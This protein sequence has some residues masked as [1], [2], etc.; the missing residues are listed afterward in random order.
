MKKKIQ[1]IQLIRAGIQLI[2]F[3]LAPA[4]F[5]RIFSAIGDI[6]KAVIG[7]SFV[8]GEQIGN[9][10]LVAA[11]FI[12]TFI[13][14]RF[15]CGFVCSFGAMQDLLW[16]A[17]R[18]F[19]L[20]RLPEKADAVLKYAKYAV[21]AFV[22]L[23]V[24]TFALPG[25]T[26]WSPWAVFGMYASPWKGVPDEL[27]FLSVGGIMLAIIIVG[28]LF[29]ERFFCKYLCP[30]GA[31][32]T[33]ASHFRIF[34]LKRNAAG[35][36][37]KCTVCTRKC[38]MAIP[39]YRYDSVRSGECINCMKCTAC[40]RG[41]MKAQPIP[42]VSGTVAAAALIGVSFAGTIS[43]SP[44][45]EPASLVK[46][47]SVGKFKD[48]IYTGSAAGYR[49]QTSVKVMVSGGNIS[50]VTIDQSGDDEQFLAQAQQG[51]IPAILA[52]QDPNVATVSG[53]TYS[54]Q[55]IINAVADALD[56]QLA[57][58]QPPTQTEPPTTQVVAE[59][60]DADGS[61]EEETEPTLP[62]NSGS[63]SDGTYT[64]FGTGFRGT[65]EVSVTVENG[66]ITQIEVTS[67]QDD[68]Q[69]FERAQSGV[70]DAIISAQSVN[71]DTV[72]GAT[73]SSNSIIE[74]VSDA[75][76]QEFSNPNSSMERGHGHMH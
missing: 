59:S 48:G 37:E 11:A 23:G 19:K 44:T 62:E 32:F 24:W 15:F 65:T 28:S 27:L 29:F 54:S 35:C 16:L 76:G 61:Y 3:I 75:L 45:T 66:A 69:F 26:V 21:L 14:G 4:L 8:F 58:T 73:F 70:I 30:L 71:V 20:P 68:E 9:I 13:W 1:T 6:Y 38:S 57:A 10:V 56:V 46:T 25:D 67:Y 60:D 42:A 12:I 51:V 50:S 34:R 52:A 36:H 17:G 43:T 31:L 53:A 2:S 47:E 18:H 39:L 22:V 74:A 33:L 7:G 72:S 55:A 63:F 64:G 40:A 5:I 41:N 49:G